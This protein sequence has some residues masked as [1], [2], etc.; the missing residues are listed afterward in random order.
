MPELRTI[1]LDKIRPSP[2]QPRETF[3]KRLIQELA[4]SMKNVDLLQPIIV[5]PNKG[6][7]QIAAGEPRWR[8]AQVAG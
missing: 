5:R 8:A 4:D 2:F 6:G 7:F 3:D 1:A